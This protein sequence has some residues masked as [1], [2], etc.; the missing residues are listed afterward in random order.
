MQAETDISTNKREERRAK[1]L[2]FSTVVALPLIIGFANLISFFIVE[3][4]HP[5]GRV[6]DDFYKKALAVHKNAEPSRLAIANGIAATLHYFVADEIVEIQLAGEHQSPS[7]LFLDFVHPVDANQDIR[8]ILN[9]TA[10]GNYRGYFS[11]V[12]KRFSEIKVQPVADVNATELWN[13]SALANSA[14]SLDLPDGVLWT[15]TL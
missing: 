14:K 12:V 2:L 13:I 7:A 5:D 8:V 4:K 10:D 1:I 15:V 6:A 11:G 9:A 3:S